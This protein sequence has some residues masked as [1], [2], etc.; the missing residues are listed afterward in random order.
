MPRRSPPTVMMF[1]QRFAAQRSISSC[2]AFSIASCSSGRIR[3]SRIVTP[4]AGAVV[5]TSPYFLSV[6]QSAGPTRSKPLAPSL[7]ASRHMS[8][9]DSFV[10]RPQLTRIS[11]CLLRP[12]RRAGAGAGCARA[13]AAAA[14][15]AA[16]TVARKARRRIRSVRVLLVVQPQEILAV[17]VAVR[18]AD[19]GVDV[20]RVRRVG[21]RREVLQVRRL[22]MIELDQDHRAVDAV[23][24]D[25]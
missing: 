7:A 23:V 4:M 17:V 19:D 21:I 12:L 8:S 1:G 13:P 24:E 2:I 6:G 3:P 9:N 16:A 14:T 15:P 20:L 10:S 22:L 25:A 18:R 11:A 5:H